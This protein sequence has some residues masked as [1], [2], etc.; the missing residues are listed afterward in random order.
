V[1]Y[2]SALDPDTPIIGLYHM[3]PLMFLPVSVITEPA[4]EPSEGVEGV[5]EGKHNTDRVLFWFVF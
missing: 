2:I 5:R 3:Y 1:L 4:H